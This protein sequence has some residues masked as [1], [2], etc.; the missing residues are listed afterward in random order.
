MSIIHRLDMETSGVLFLGKTTLANR[1]LTRQF[2]ER[3]V[4][5]LYL[6]LTDR[7]V[8]EKEFSSVSTLVRSGHKYVS[9]LLRANA[10]RAETRF[11]VA[12]Y[13][14]GRTLLQAEPITGRTHQIRV[15]AAENGFPILGDTLYGGTS[16]ARL[17]LHA[18][19][20]RLRH[21]ASGAELTF[22][23]TVD[24]SSDITVELRRAIIS[25]EATNAYRVIHGASDH[26]PGWYVDR[27]GDFLLAQA[28]DPLSPAQRKKLEDLLQELSLRGAYHKKILRRAGAGKGEVSPQPVLGAKVAVEFPI[29]ENGLKFALSFQEGYSVGLFLDQRENRRRLLTKHVAADFSLREPGPEAGTVLNTFAYTCGFSVCAARTGLHVTSLDLSKSHLDWGKRNFLLNHLDPGAHDFIFGDAL[30]WLRRLAN[31]QRQFD[32]VILDPPTFSRSKEHGAF[33]AE[34][35]YERLTAAALRVLK[36]NGVL[37]ACINTASLRPEDFLAK[38][39]HAI[40]AAGRRIRQRHYVPQPPDFP[41]TREEPAYLKTVWLRLE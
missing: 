35:D 33:Q 31:K 27:L 2:G 26:W 11:R 39:Q 5:K 34:R 29:R 36:K 41:I 12:Q 9:S 8:R 4:S 38:V 3:T 17:C 37:L 14:P 18:A 13:E 40:G 16:A 15:H 19:E 23:A 24:F 6:L 22:T 32:M 7:P 20:L 1:S 25:P 10:E 21:P 28:E 30:D